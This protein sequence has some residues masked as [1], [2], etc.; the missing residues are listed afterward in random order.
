MMGCGSGRDF[1][2]VKYPPRRGWD[3]VG[4]RPSDDFMH[5][6]YTT[7]LL[8][9]CPVCGRQAVFEED[10]YNK[11]PK[12]ERARVFIGF[13]PTCELRTR[14]PGTLR[15]AVTQWQRGEYSPDSW[16]HCHRPQFDSWGVSELCN[17]V[18]GTAYEDLRMY[19]EIMM[20]GDIRI[21]RVARTS[22]KQRVTE[23][24]EEETYS[25]SELEV[26]RIDQFFRTSPLAF[27][28]DRDAVMSKLRKE[29]FPDLT[30]KERLKI[31]LDP[32]EMWRGKEIAKKCI[33]ERNL[34][35]Q[36]S[37]EDT[38]PEETSV[39]ISKRTRRRATRKKI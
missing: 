23:P 22:H 33:A 3:V 19:V 1:D 9:P 28:L 30:P 38:Q 27:A 21:P 6:G 29:L 12:G 4:G 25:H 20:G 31:S 2:N 14:T 26:R 16:L 5:G 24:T 34:K 18:C 7:N 10:S 13:C 8:K 39:S 15:E 37:A 32:T 17:V 35:K 11:A 36:P